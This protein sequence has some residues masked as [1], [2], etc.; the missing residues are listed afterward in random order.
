[1]P[2]AGTAIELKRALDAVTAMLVA[3]FPEEHEISPHFTTYRKGPEVWVKVR[4]GVPSV[5]RVIAVVYPAFV[6]SST[7]AVLPEEQAAFPHLITLTSVLVLSLYETR[8]KPSDVTTIEVDKEAIDPP[9]EPATVVIVL[10]D[11]QIASPHFTTFIS[12]F[13]VS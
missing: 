10:P 8:G 11:E 12:E 6:E 5:L 1:L 9:P 4:T 2:S 3:T 13:V 7:T